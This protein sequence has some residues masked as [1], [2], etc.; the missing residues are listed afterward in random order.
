M[1]FLGYYGE[2]CS[3]TGYLECFNMLRVGHFYSMDMKGK[4][5]WQPY[6][7][8]RRDQTCILL[9]ICCSETFEVRYNTRYIRNQKKVRKRKKK[10]LRLLTTTTPQAYDLSETYG[11]CRKSTKL[12][13]ISIPFLS[14][15]LEAW[16]WNPI[17]EVLSP[18]VIFMLPQCS[19]ASP[20]HKNGGCFCN[21]QSYF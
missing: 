19:V 3:F 7:Q 12:N 21:H 11:L 8:L 5:R 13:T 14:F 18:M 10:K 4:V 17:L 1:D 15:V 2:R 9:S 6:F 16:M 20:V